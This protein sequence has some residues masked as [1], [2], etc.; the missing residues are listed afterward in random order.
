MTDEP[1]NPEPE[2]TPEP[3]PEPNPE[4]N[5][6]YERIFGA[7]GSSGPGVA[8]DETSEEIS[9]NPD[10]AFPELEPGTYPVI[11]AERPT[12]QISQNGNPMMLVKFNSLDPAMAGVFFPWQRCMLSGGFVR[13]TV[14]F[15]KAVGLDE[16][17]KTGQ[18]VPAEIDGRRLIVHVRHQ[19]NDP[20]YMEI[21]KVE[22]HPD[23]PIP[24]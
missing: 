1:T 22:R 15:L 20:E 13:E 10:D 4:T 23:G 9:F 8:I 6:D 12:K 5:E 19:K 18:I 21:H 11:V 24:D 17:A 3:E 7:G 16:M 2:P 14:A